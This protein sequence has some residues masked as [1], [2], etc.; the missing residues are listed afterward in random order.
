MTTQLGMFAKHWRPG[1]V[2]T[3][4]AA[5]IGNEAAAALHR[6]F[7]QTLLNRFQNIADRQILCFTP[8]DSADSFRLLRLGCWTLEAQASGNL[9]TRMQHYF[10]A[11]LAV[12]DSPCVVLIGSDSPDLP[13]EYVAEAFNKLRDFPVV[14][15]PTVDG[16]YYLIGLSQTVPP[17]FDNIPWSTPE[18]WPQTIARLAAAK[19]P[20]HLLPPWYDVDDIAGLR[21]LHDSLPP[22]DALRGRIAALLTPDP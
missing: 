4:L 9:G 2:K 7:V 21:R 13:L 19:I 11:A 22:N 8:A 18:V 17:I 15:G 16:G 6:H 5:S 1:A 3:R 10:S 14:V 20:Y 12:P